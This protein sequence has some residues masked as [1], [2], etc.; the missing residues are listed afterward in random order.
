MR[1]ARVAGLL[2]PTALELRPERVLELVLQAQALVRPLQALERVLQ[3]QA[4]VRTLQTLELKQ[5]PKQVPVPQQQDCQPVL[6][7]GN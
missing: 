2:Q 5:V 3:A 7:A 4:Q 6:Q 1:D